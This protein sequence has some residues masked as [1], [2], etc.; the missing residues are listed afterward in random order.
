MKNV[1]FFVLAFALLTAVALLASCGGEVPPIENDPPVTEAPETNAPETNIPDTPDTDVPETLP[2]V[3][4]PEPTYELLKLDFETDLALA[5]Y[6]ASVDGIEINPGL[7]GGEV[8]DG[9]WVY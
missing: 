5:D 7:N 4:E 8:A 9:K 6:I 3:V 2:V 1:K